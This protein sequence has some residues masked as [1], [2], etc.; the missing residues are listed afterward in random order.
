M[1]AIF[2]PP[3]NLVDKNA[4]KEADATP[5]TTP[6]VAPLPVQNSP[7]QRCQGAWSSTTRV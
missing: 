1:R 5:R 2:F 7:V 4:K 3:E 6:G